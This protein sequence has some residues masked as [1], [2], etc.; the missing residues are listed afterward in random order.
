MFILRPCIF[1]LLA[2]LDYP[3]DPVSHRWLI[4]QPW[5][6]NKSVTPRNV[7]H[8]RDLRISFV[9]CFCRT[10]LRLKTRCISSAGADACFFLYFRWMSSGRRPSPAVMKCIACFAGRVKE[11][12]G[13]KNTSLPN[14]Y[15]LP[16]SP[17]QMQKFSQFLTWYSSHFCYYCLYLGVYSRI[18]SRL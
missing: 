4:L 2:R 18:Y 16:I 8:L 7:Y 3:F 14:L 6:L 5:L 10:V 9:S 11:G 12:N 15:Q 1:R 13:A 17:P